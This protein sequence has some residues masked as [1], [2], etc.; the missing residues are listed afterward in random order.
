MT[1][2]RAA[3][4]V[5]VVAAVLLPGSIVARGETA[6]ESVLKELRE[7]E[8]GAFATATV[9]ASLA[10]VTLLIKSLLEWRFADELAATRRH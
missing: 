4:G 7:L 8:A 2:S 5:A 9:L 1:R 10:L 6:G 3:R